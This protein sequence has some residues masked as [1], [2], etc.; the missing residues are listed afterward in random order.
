MNIADSQPCWHL[1][2]GP[3]AG[4][5]VRRLYLVTAQAPG[6]PVLWLDD[7]RPLYLHAMH[8]SQCRPYDQ[9][10]GVL[11]QAAFAPVILERFWGRIEPGLAIDW[12]ATMSI[13][14]PALS[15]HITIRPR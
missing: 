6:W 5:L 1:G 10:P 7:G 11:Q 3:R 15:G 14:R 13:F 4:G 8:W 2:A 12:V 9:S